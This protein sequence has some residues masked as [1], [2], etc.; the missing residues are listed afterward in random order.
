MLKQD[1]M[2]LSD[3]RLIVEES[4]QSLSRVFFTSSGSHVHNQYK[5]KSFC[6]NDMHHE[7]EEEEG[8]LHVSKK[9]ITTT[10]IMPCKVTCILSPSIG[11]GQAGQREWSWAWGVILKR[12]GLPTCSLKL[13]WESTQIVS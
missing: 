3:R 12:G 6:T 13:F 11:M 5:F 2:I 8:R 4:S 10:Q 9:S 7:E 1:K